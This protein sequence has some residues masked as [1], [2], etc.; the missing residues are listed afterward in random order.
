MEA[1]YQILLL[2][3]AEISI[4]QKLSLLKSI[5]RTLI[6]VNEK[7][8][9]TIVNHSYAD[10]ICF[11]ALN[12]LLTGFSSY[13]FTSRLHKKYFIS[14]HRRIFCLCTNLLILLGLFIPEILICF[15]SGIQ[16][17]FKHIR[18]LNKKYEMHFLADIHQV[19]SN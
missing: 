15:S 18:N 3:Q 17:F 5:S 10:L 6:N 9:S 2:L 1:A 19:C 16:P 7:F 4:F 12:N 14:V 8:S 11:H 13:Y